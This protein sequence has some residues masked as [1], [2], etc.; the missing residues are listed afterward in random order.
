MAL[1]QRD[2][3][4]QKLAPERPDES[5]DERML[6][7]HMEGCRNLLDPAALEERRNSE[8]VD[9]VVVPVPGA[10][11]PDVGPAARPPGM[12]RGC[13]PHGIAFRSCWITHCMVGL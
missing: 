8:A 12:N 10:L 9:A 7:R 3:V 11:A 5:L 4:I 1:A 6:P 2:D 13:S